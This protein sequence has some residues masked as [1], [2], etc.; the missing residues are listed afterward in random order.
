MRHLRAVILLAAA[1][2]LV[3]APSGGAEV[4]DYVESQWD[5]HKYSGL[6]GVQ[7]VKIGQGARASAMGGI[8]SANADDINAAFWNP[9]GLTDIRGT[10]WTATYTRWLVNTKV[11]SAAAAL[12][13]GSAR[14]GVLGMTVM[15]YRPESFEETTIYQPSGTGQNVDTGDIAI[16]LIYAIKL[17]DKF[18]FGA[19]VSWLHQTLFTF[20]VNHIAIDL[21]TRFHTGFRSL[22]VAMCLRNYGPDIEVLRLRA[23]MPMAYSLSLA[24]EVYGEKGDPAYLTLSAETLY[25][26]DYSMRYHVGGELWLQNMIALRAG[27]RFTYVAD[28]YSLGAG[29]KYDIPG[30]KSVTV[31]VSYSKMDFFEAPIR[32]TIGGTF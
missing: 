6:G 27:H 3:L 9:A 24:S 21:G 28:S 31:D 23:L 4:L 32:V 16:G 26:A 25:E 11:F 5:Q 12:N 7:F 8:F 2:V 1:G 14:G 30:G 20:S 15:S 18:S 19:R 10:A 22:R 17:T 13:T 29:V